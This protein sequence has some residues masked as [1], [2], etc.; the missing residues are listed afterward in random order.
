MYIKILIKYT[1]IKLLMLN[2]VIN[3]VL[4]MI[5]TNIYIIY[6]MQSLYIGM[7]AC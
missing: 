3:K 4:N 6:T 2:Q 7:L 1:R 5:N